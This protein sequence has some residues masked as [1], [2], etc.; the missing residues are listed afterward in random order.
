MK[1]TGA[2][3]KCGSRDVFVV[4]GHA[5]AYGVGN[6]IPDGLTVF[7]CIPVDRYVCGQC[8]FSEE[9]LRQEDIERARHAKRAHPL[10]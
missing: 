8:G 9:W 10:R 5:G 2:C 6:N 3:P 4:D 1:N 7:S